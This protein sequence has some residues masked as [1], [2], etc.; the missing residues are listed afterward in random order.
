M[1]R[2]KASEGGGI[3]W[4]H[5]SGSACL[6]FAEVKG[7]TQPEF[8]SLFAK[9]EQNSPVYDPAL[10]ELSDSLNRL[11]TETQAGGRY[12]QG[13]GK[14]V[15]IGFLVTGD[16]FLLVRKRGVGK[17]ERLE[18]LVDI[19]TLTDLDSMTSDQLA[20][21]LRIRREG[22]KNAGQWRRH[23]V[24][25][26]S[27]P[28]PSSTGIIICRGGGKSCFVTALAPQ[29]A[30]VIGNYFPTVAQDS[31]VYD[32]SLHEL[33]GKLNSLLNETQVR[34]KQKSSRDPMAQIGLVI[35]GHGLLPAW[36]IVASDDDHHGDGVGSVDL[37]DM[38]DA[39]R[40][41]FLRVKA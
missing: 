41:Q 4:C 36:K 16:G 15:K 25:Q 24:T 3:V 23:T 22:G 26:K 8:I 39:Q 11:V 32:P 13:E 31:P 5:D 6:T 35:T 1:P 27:D 21:Y 18:E 30:T 12:E 37:D 9:V 17:E 7:S 33:I 28:D 40:D 10:D 19:E 14:E 2:Q 20:E 38:T 29:G 34:E